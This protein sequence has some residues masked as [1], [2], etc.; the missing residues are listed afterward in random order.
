MLDCDYVFAA[1]GLMRPNERFFSQYLA[2]TTAPKATK[3]MPKPAGDTVTG[4]VQPEE[5][6]MLLQV[7]GDLISVV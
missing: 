3:P 2:R 1:N 6:T 4:F 7:I 5:D